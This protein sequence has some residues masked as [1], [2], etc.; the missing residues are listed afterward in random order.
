M[1]AG[2]IEWAEQERESN[3]PL[4]KGVLH[5]GSSQAKTL[6]GKPHFTVSLRAGRKVLRPPMGHVGMPTHGIATAKS[7][8]PEQA[9]QLRWADRRPLI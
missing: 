3:S 8:L 1:C 5:E 9:C 7:T 4:P 6:T 2:T